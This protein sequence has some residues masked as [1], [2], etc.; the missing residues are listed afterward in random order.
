MYLTSLNILVSKED[1]DYS[2]VLI[3]LVSNCDFESPIRR[4]PARESNHSCRF[5]W[6]SSVPRHV[7]LL[8]PALWRMVSEYISPLD[9]ISTSYAVYFMIAM[10]NFQGNTGLCTWT[11]AQFGGIVSASVLILVRVESNLPHY[12]CHRHTFVGPKR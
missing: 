8:A 3:Y 10:P 11:N 12:M 4:R 2:P 1:P 5:T 9:P 7:C 6:P